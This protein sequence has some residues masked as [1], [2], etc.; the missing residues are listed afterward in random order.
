MMF[1]NFSSFGGFAMWHGLTGLFCLSF[2]IGII[3]IIAWAIKTLKKE[4]LLKWSISLIFIGIIGWF[5]IMSLG[6]FGSSKF[7][8]RYGYGMMNP[9]VWNCVQDKEC[10]DDMGQYM[11]RMMG[12]QNNR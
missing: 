1:N 8:G 11:Q 9:E 2:L 7:S 12:L 4:Q 3:F 5:L 6:G 10:Y